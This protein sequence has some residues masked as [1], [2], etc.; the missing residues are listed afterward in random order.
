[1]AEVERKLKTDERRLREH[2]TNLLQDAEDEE[3]LAFKER[4]AISIQ[5]VEEKLA[6]EIENAKVVH[7]RRTQTLQNDFENDMERFRSSLVDKAR[8]ARQVCNQEMSSI[9]S[10]SQ[11]RLIELKR[12]HAAHLEQ[13]QR[14]H[15]DMVR[16]ES[17]ECY[18]HLCYVLMFRTLFHIN[19]K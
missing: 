12:N 1:M 4:L 3:R 2:Y 15:D 13:L 17:T 16:R 9:Q 5:H 14:E 19:R 6:E 10:N 7:T 8:R 18:V 11:T